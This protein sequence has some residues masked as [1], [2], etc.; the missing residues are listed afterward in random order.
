MIVNYPIALSLINIASSRI[1][2]IKLMNVT[3]HSTDS[4][5]VHFDFR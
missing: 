5:S 2:L 4:F 3:R 1:N